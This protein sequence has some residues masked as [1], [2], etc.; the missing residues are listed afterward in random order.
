MAFNSP[1]ITAAHLATT[2]AFA[3]DISISRSGPTAI[4]N[5]EKAA[6][7]TNAAL[8][9][10]RGESRESDLRLDVGDAMDVDLM[11]P[12]AKTTPGLN[13][14]SAYA[15]GEQSLPASKDKYRP[16][17][18]Q[19]NDNLRADGVFAA[20][21][22]L[23]ASR[24]RPIGQGDLSGPA[25]HVSSQVHPMD[26]DSEMHGAGLLL[27]AASA[28]D[29]DSAA[30]VPITERDVQGSE[31]NHHSAVGIAPQR[32]NRTRK[33]TEANQQPSLKNNSGAEERSEAPRKPVLM[34]TLKIPPGSTIDGTHLGPKQGSLLKTTVSNRA[35]P[36]SQ[37]PNWP[38]PAPQAFTSVNLPPKNVLIPRPQPYRRPPASRSAANLKQIVLPAPGVDALRA[39]RK[40]TEQVKVPK[41]KGATTAKDVPA[42]LFLQSRGLEAPL[43]EAPQVADTEAPMPMLATQ[44]E[45]PRLA[46]ARKQSEQVKAPRFNGATTVKDIP[47]PL[48]SQSRRLE[49]PPA[50]AKQVAG[51]EAPMPMLA[52][53]KEI[54]RPAYAKP[55]PSV[56]ASGTNSPVSTGDSDAQVDRPAREAPAR[57]VNIPSVDVRS[58]ARKHFITLNRS[59]DWYGADEN[60]NLQV[61]PPA[62]PSPTLSN[63]LPPIKASIPPPD[64]KKVTMPQ[65]ATGNG[66][67]HLGHTIAVFKMAST[68]EFRIEGRG[69]SPSHPKK[70]APLVPK[71]NFLY[72]E[73]VVRGKDKKTGG[74]FPTASRDVTDLPH[75]ANGG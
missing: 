26:I 2:A 52:T 40:Q 4:A 36:A 28:V 71:N 21:M 49:N 73:P 57:A 50:E 20:A 19:P 25:E 64:P 69:S 22:P 10:F 18:E 13:S 72:Y 67:N 43:A 53:Q 65:T 11:S 70:I 68:P 51:T 47:A 27:W 16:T 63:A 32:R 14:A 56:S 29:Q 61:P 46:Y 5:A 23:E 15:N 7:S 54:P 31:P 60:Q 55:G 48:S 42:P 24:I 35:A 44:K 74:L 8:K 6:K 38:V 3:R 62:T 12:A 33:G 39:A 30:S 1:C 41:L 45:I 66:N 34:V 75:I 9:V 59:N 17:A 37:T 58:I